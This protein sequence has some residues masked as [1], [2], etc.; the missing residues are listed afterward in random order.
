ME[1]SDVTP[2]RQQYLDI[3]KQ[4]PN[5]ILF[6]RLG[7]FY[8]T[9]DED[10]ELVAHE[11]DIVLTSRPVGGNQRVPLAG[12]PY[13]SVENYLGRLINKGYHIAI[14]EQIGDQPTKGIFPREV[15]RVVT[16]GTLVEA[17]LLPGD[18]RNYLS[19][20]FFNEDRFSIASAEISTGEFNVSESSPASPS[21]IRAEIQRLSPAELIY[22]E[23]LRLPDGIQCHTTP[24]PSWK[25]ENGKCA[26]VFSQHFNTTSFEGFG[27][28]A[29]SF[30]VNTIGA[31][32]QYLKITTPSV[33]EF[34]T[35]LKLV[36]LNEFMTLDAH[37]TRNLELKQSLRGLAKGSL[38]DLLDRTQ[39][40]MGK[41]MV[42]LWVSQPLLDIAQIEKRLDGV[43]YF[44]NN[45]LQRQ[46]FREKVKRI[47]DLERL[48][49]KVASGIV[50]PRELLRLRDS[51]S[52]LPSLKSIFREPTDTL[53]EFLDL[54]VSFPQEL[55]L[56]ERSISED[57]PATLQNIGVIK[58][59]FS[60]ELDNIISASANAREWINSLESKEKERTGIKTLKVGYN[61]VFGYYIEIS[62]GQ[63]NN[64]PS[65]YI[66]KQ[67]LVNAE[68]YITPEMKEYETLILNAD[69]QIH[70][71][72]SLIYKQVCVELAKSA[73][74][75]LLS[76]NAIAHLDCLSALAECSSMYGFV[77]PQLTMDDVFEII[78]GRHPVVANN[79]SETKFVPNDI[80]FE[81]GER[82]RIL[83]GPNMAGKSTY[84]RQ[85]AII[86][87]MAQM[88]CFVPA[89]SARIGIVDRI[90]TRIGAQD[91]IHSGH[92]TFMV[93]MI[94]TSNILHHATDR[95]LVI[96][97]EI[98]R[99]TSTYDG[100]SIAWAVIEYIH[101]HPGSR[102]KT[103]FATHYH[104][105][106]RLAEILPGVRNY[107]VAVAEQ[108]GDVT[109]LHRIVP[110]GSDRSYGIH[111]AQ[112]AGIPSPIISRAR[113]ILME[114]ERESGANRKDQFVAQQ[115]ALFPETNPLVDEI[116]MI[117][118]NNL[119]PLEA[120]N[121]IYAWK[122]KYKP[123][124]S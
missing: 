105:L 98:G 85:A 22:P 49:S 40:P 20:L 26:T 122:Q 109:F 93:E 50:L 39:T 88:G 67:T 59:G 120:L 29:N 97:D 42:E 64:A 27:F 95:S 8:E 107:N 70:Q 9:F 41:R 89:K 51:I 78:D 75:F 38:L 56:L 112:L 36:H 115:V 32:L 124:G 117:D 92:S 86:T 19:A 71:I 10:A 53:N 80:V 46:E 28:S 48:I 116:S 25:F 52:L 84:L 23:H 34:L 47:A 72:E 119:S 7:D 15:Q 81:P 5:T 57:S 110:G 94:E 90:F 33:L 65:E 83:T 69:E 31:I 101:N 11:L 82:V 2:V 123:N 24:L 118:V 63:A 103:L 44:F 68:R 55:S 96:L 62:A 1:R 79:L 21:A 73:K 45:P 14:A 30:C 76:A 91:E 35:D 16:P 113:E 60:A 61:K 74:R 121:K 102:A 87:L 13:H 106:V 12:I 114:L 104:E 37:T 77:R 100:V 111:V 108:D 58:P 4:Y 66:R 18:S 6:F 17:T 99:G 3:K 54:I 43:D